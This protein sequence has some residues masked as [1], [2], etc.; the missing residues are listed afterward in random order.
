MSF[1]PWS[2]NSIRVTSLVLDPVDDVGGS[3]PN[4]ATNP[5]PTGS[6]AD[7]TPPVEGADRDAQEVCD[8]LRRQQLASAHVRSLPDPCAIVFLCYYS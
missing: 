2:F 1:L 4:V 8:L 3:V 7:V 5:E 6:I